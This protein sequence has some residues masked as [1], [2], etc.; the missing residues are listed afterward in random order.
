MW[1][2]DIWENKRCSSIFILKPWSWACL[3]VLWDLWSRN[4]HSYKTF[5]NKESLKVKTSHYS[6]S[7][8]YPLII[9]SE[10]LTELFQES[11][12][13]LLYFFLQI[14][15]PRLNIICKNALLII[16]K[17]IS[18]G[19]YLS[20]WKWSD[21]LWYKLRKYEVQFSPWTYEI[22][23]FSKTSRFIWIYAY[24]AAK[25]YHTGSWTQQFLFKAL[26]RR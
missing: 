1:H 6:S 11:F 16:I 10:K 7:H 5:A 4:T 2:F 15:F 9:I 24:F 17:K 3:I 21:I 12:R 13:H 22:R 19:K 8:A 20:T 25:F 23:L 14:K 18:S 26:H